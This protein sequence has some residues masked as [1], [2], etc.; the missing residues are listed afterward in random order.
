MLGLLLLK[1]RQITLYPLWERAEGEEDAW[2]TSRTYSRAPTGWIPSVGTY[3]SP[4]A[5][6]LS[7]AERQEGKVVHREFWNPT[8][9]KPGVLMQD[10]DTGKFSNCDLD[11]LAEYF[12]SVSPVDRKVYRYPI[13]LSEEF[14]RL[15][16]EDVEQFQKC[17]RRF[18]HLVR[19]IAWYQT[20]ERFT[21][22]DQIRF[23]DATMALRI[24]AAY[25]ISTI[26]ESGDDGFI[27]RWAATSLISGY[28]LMALLDLTNGLLNVCHECGR[29]FASSAGRA[30]FC[31]PRCRKTSL[32]REWRGR[33]AE[34]IGG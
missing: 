1:V 21:P 28:A 13:P 8:W 20:E 5:L 6:E 18:A 7:P 2:P 25:T 19:T 23:K 26:G 31:S 16:A 12:P 27:R 9:D 30:R 3:A 24:L 32:Q 4:E 15:Y 17:A 14:W 33:K 11:V 34:K 22:E 29:V 10:P